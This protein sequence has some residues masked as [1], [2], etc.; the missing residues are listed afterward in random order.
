MD[1]E[2]RRIAQLVREN[3]ARVIA[4]QFPEGLKRYGPSLAMQI[5]QDLG[6]RVILSGDPCYGACDLDLESDADLVFHFGHAQIPQLDVER[7]HFVEVRSDI[8]VAPV[9]RDALKVIDG[10]RI[11]VVTTVQHIHK[12]RDIRNQ[13][14]SQGRECQIGQ[15]DNRI[16]Y[17]GQV[18]GCNFS[19]AQAIDVDEYLYL[20]SGLFHALG[21]SLATGKQVVAADPFLRKISVP[22]V[23]AIVRQR[24]AVI[25]KALDA[26]TFCVL[27]GTKIGQ[28]RSDLAR[29]L[30]QEARQRQCKAYA[31]S[32]NE[33]SPWLL[34]QFPADAYVNTACPRIGIDE[35]SRFKAPLLSPIEFEIV[36]GKRDLSDYAFDEL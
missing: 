31:V 32:V 2:T 20:G 26:G 6:I 7:I 34:Y 30:V 36:I 29:E 10:H 17:P 21:V 3:D 28:R 11:G 1:F 9:V 13:I 8:D 35:V 16:R 18:L 14:E 33:V 27:I 25:A 12:L 23:R 22:D 24:Y 4:L 19:S 5:E 15:G